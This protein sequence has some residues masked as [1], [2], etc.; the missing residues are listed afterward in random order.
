MSVPSPVPQSNEYS[1]ATLSAAHLLRRAGF[2]GTPA[3]VEAAAQS[4]L[5]ETTRRMFDFSGASVL[6][7]DAIIA[8][9]SDALPQT[10]KMALRDRLPVLVAQCWWVYRMVAS[11]APLQ[12]K[13]TLFWHNHFTSRDGNGWPLVAQNQ[14]YRNYALGNFR[15]LALEVS[16]NPEMLTY[17]N[18]NQ[19]YKAHPNENY[20][21]ELME[22][23][24]CGRVGP[25]GV[26]P[27]Y[28]EDDVKAA[29]RAFSGWN[30]R[31]R[32]FYYNPNQ[33]DDDAKT[34]MG[35][36]GDLNG[37]DVV[38]ILVSLPA[39]AYRICGKLFRY[40]AYDDPEPTVMHALVQT[41]Y[42]T[43]YEIKP[44]VEQILTSDAFYSPKARNAVMKSPAEIVIGSIHMLGLTATFAPPVDA[45]YGDDPIPS[46]PAAPAPPPTATPAAAMQPGMPMSQQA[47]VPSALSVQATPAR[48]RRRAGLSTPVG[49][50]IFLANQMRDMGQTLFAPP[51][52]KGWD[53]GAM[54]INT[55][56]LQARARFGTAISNLPPALLQT[57]DL[58]TQLAS[59]TSASASAKG[60]QAQTAA[61]VSQGGE[62]ETERIVDMICRQLGPLVLP[63]ATRDILLQYAATETNPQQQARGVLALLMSA[64]QYQTS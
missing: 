37:D 24:T 64:P 36:T 21:R 55:D 53:G 20:A 6:D 9:L 60:G 4:G 62:V 43:G 26:T 52:V 63:A 12:E 31:Q 2:G 5:A 25:D 11:P 58:W 40:F 33:H 39:T 47:I 45:L 56:T 54:W 44:I 50:L 38:D 1:P 7:D 29:A 22:L 10:D 61:L 51:T 41:Y 15:T 19:N 59:A 8:R 42:R 18:N 34:F 49:R 28:T 27:N 48:V 46:S 17:L 13:M 30:L 23:F 35:R 16:K 57:S 14:L 3:E 32:A